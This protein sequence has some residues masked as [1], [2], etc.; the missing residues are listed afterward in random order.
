MTLSPYLT[1][2]F[3]EAYSTPG[4][5]L[6]HC[7]GDHMK[8]YPKVTFAIP[9]LNAADILDQCLGS[10]LSQEY[11]EKE[12]LVI[13]GGS[14]DDTLAIAR[15]YGSRIFHGGMNLGQCRQVGF[16][17][18]AGEIVAM[19]DSDIII[20]HKQWLARAVIPFSCRKDISTVW[21]VTA[22]PPGGTLLNRTYENFEW[23]FMLREWAAG[24]RTGGGGNSLLRRKMVE[25]VGGI[26]IPIQSGE[27]FY[28]ATKLFRRGY[29]VAVH[30]DPL[31]HETHQ[32]LHEWIRTDRRIHRHLRVSGFNLLT[33]ESSMTQYASRQLATM[34]HNMILGTALDG[35][36]SWLAVPLIAASRVSGF[37]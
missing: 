3:E 25:E 18:A 2:L 37:L 6:V 19:F 22:A 23:A 31:W 10:V 8:E 29:K 30:E 35:D 11:P 13:D 26:D 28:I 36:P 17:Q 9:T 21:P 32:T 34:L 4:S 12:I 7:N 24:R 15:A 20:P 5:N 33:G 16:E 27:D 14:T 1:R